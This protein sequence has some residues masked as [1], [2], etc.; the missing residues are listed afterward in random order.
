MTLRGLATVTRRRFNRLAY[1]AGPLAAAHVA[2]HSNRLDRLTAAQLDR[3]DF[4]T[5][6]DREIDRAMDRRTISSDHQ[7]DANP[8]ADEAEADRLR[9][10]GAEQMTPLT[11]LR[12]LLWR[13][14]DH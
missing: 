10:L 4:W 14:C 2:A 8:W 9:L 3:A 11:I 13:D 5:L 1:A 12:N 7:S 6:L